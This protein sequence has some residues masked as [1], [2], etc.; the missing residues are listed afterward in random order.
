MTFQLKRK[1]AMVACG[2]ALTTVGFVVIPPILNRISRKAYKA[3]VDT[4]DIDF[5]DMG[6]EIVKKSDAPEVEV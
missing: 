2:A 5:D 1:I 6:P 3:S 4:S